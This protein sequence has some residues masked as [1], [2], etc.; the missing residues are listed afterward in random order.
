MTD[1]TDDIDRRTFLRRAG[2][3]AVG[4]GV[5]AAGVDSL[6]IEP[7][8]LEV[9]TH[10]RTVPA[11]RA[12]F[13]TYRV[14][15]LVDVHLDGFGDMHRTIVERL[16]DFQPDLLAIPGDMVDGGA[17]LDEV[18]RL[19]SRLAETADR[20]VATLGNWEYWC[21]IPVEDIGAMY[22]R[23]GIELLVGEHRTYRDDVAVVGT[24][25][26][27]TGR[28]NPHEA[29]RPVAGAGARILLTHAPGVL[30]SYH[31]SLPTFDLVLSGHTHGGQFELFGWAPICPPG[32]GRFVAGAYQTP[33]GPTYVSRGVG[34]SLV[35]ARFSC[36][37]ELAL[38]TL[39][40][41]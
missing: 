21:D 17:P 18:A 20:C 41:A 28:A 36:R 9:T 27:A 39:R 14:A 3:T 6:L 30:E 24:D 37:P 11:D 19:C 38:F 29:C 16:A 1:H 22:R 7:N 23:T 35:P 2:Y 40:A 8:W 31:T 10:E 25:D 15:H 26:G 33:A 12:G 13:D 32:S 4:A 5:A 34:T